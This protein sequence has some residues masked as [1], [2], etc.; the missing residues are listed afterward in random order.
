[1]LL[2]FVASGLYSE[3]P[4]FVSVPEREFQ[5][6]VKLISRKG[7]ITVRVLTFIP[8]CGGLHDCRSKSLYLIFQLEILMPIDPSSLLF[9]AEAV[10]EKE[11]P[12]FK[13]F[14]SSDSLKLMFGIT[15]EKAYK[16]LTKK[17]EYRK[18]FD[19]RKRADGLEIEVF[20]PRTM[21]FLIR[22]HA[23]SQDS[24]LVEKIAQQHPLMTIKR[25]EKLVES[26]LPIFSGKDLNWKTEV[27]LTLPF[28][29][30]GYHLTYFEGDGYAILE[31]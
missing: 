8:P 12:T 29:D 5:K 15:K 26:G 4:V 2:D 1:M 22:A 27:L 17:K 24:H 18:L 6:I 9:F 20:K 7:E 30:G 11:G 21:S 19:I 13:S 31:K 28:M 14:I 25:M 23:E 16:G 10:P 3:H